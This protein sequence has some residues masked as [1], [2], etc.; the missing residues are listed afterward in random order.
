M[1]RKFLILPLALLAACSSS[2]A[3]RGLNY[4]SA[5]ASSMGVGFY[6][7]PGPAPDSGYGYSQDKAIQV[8]GAKNEEGSLNEHKYL[9]SLRGPNGEDIRYARTGSCCMFDTPNAM[10]GGRGLLDTYI[11][12]WEGLKKPITL[13]LNMYDAGPL[14]VPAGFTKVGL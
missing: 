10:F 12:T 4:T 2:R 11:I 13:Y 7:L 8:G 6:G 3:P 9:N 14:Y 5:K 1:N